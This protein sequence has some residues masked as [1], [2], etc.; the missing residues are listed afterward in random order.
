VT[1][2]Q[3]ERVAAALVELLVRRAL[4]RL[5]EDAEREQPTA[6]KEAGR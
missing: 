3:L 4:R 2:E 6:P 1:D 5:Q